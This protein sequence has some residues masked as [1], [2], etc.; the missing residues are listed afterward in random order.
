MSGVDMIYDDV[1]SADLTLGMAVNVYPLE[2]LGD[3][4][5]N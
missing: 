1:G 4:N 3:R 2:C 5:I